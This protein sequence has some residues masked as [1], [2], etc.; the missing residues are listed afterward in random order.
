M[1][2]MYSR[3][4]RTVALNNVLL[5][6]PLNTWREPR[7]TTV[8]G[9]VGIFIFGGLG[10]TGTL[11]TADY[12]DNLKVASLMKHCESCVVCHTANRGGSHD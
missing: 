4:K 2:Y 11:L 10:I 8:I 5:Q 7:R 6:E 9:L 12:I 1:K 3:H